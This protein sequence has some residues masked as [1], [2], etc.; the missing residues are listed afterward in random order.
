VTERQL[1]ELLHEAQLPDSEAAEE[2]AWRVVRTAAVDRPAPGPRRGARVW[3]L[4]AVAA[5]VVLVAA[6]ALSPA[7][8]A[9][10]D[11]LQ[12]AVKPGRPE[13]RPTLTSLPAPGRLLVVSADGA[14][15]VQPDGFRRRLGDYGDAGWSPRGLFVVATRGRELVALEPGGVER[16][17]LAR[18]QLIHSPAWSPDGF[19]IAYLSGSSLRVVAGDGSGDRRLRSTVAAT[20]PAWRPGSVRRLSYADRRGRIATVDPDSGR[21][22]WRSQPGSPVRRLAWTPDGRRLVALTAS[23]LRVL[24]ERGRMLAER[25]FGVGERATAMAVEPSGDSVAVAVHEGD[26]RSRVDSLALRGS[27]PRLRRLFAGDGSFTDLSWS[28]DGRWLL[29]AWREADQWVFLRSARVRKVDAVAHIAR[30]FDPGANLPRGFP[31]IG[32]WCCAR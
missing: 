4:P 16:W 7:G 6:L 5:A 14:W 22:L 19:R 21:R 28:P 1:S 24:S 32:G 31:R 20:R 13:A 10:A 26:G 15:V 29:V 18:P 8:A 12:D 25:S 27:S 30:H 11:W 17:S 2:R 23:S 3:L 9:V